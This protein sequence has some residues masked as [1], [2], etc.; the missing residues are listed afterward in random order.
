[1]LKFPNVCSSNFVLRLTKSQSYYANK[2]LKHEKRKH[3]ALLYEAV[4]VRINKLPP[5]LFTTQLII[6]K[7]RYNS[8]QSS[9]LVSSALNISQ[10]SVEG[11]ALCTHCI[12]C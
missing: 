11:T 2:H 10:F 8:G 12:E 7:Q 3:S 5:K 6:G 9:S 1:M 4:K